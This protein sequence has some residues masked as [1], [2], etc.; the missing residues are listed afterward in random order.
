MTKLS[1][2]PRVSSTN[3]FT[4]EYRKEDF[5]RVCEKLRLLFTFSHSAT[6]IELCNKFSKR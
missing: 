1:V 2:S 4:R 5:D 3:L 6:F